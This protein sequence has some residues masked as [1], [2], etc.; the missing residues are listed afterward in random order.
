M[1]LDFGH[2]FFMD[3]C[4]KYDKEMIVKYDKE[5]ICYYCKICYNNKDNE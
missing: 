5:M 3:I 4:V 1:T 2:L